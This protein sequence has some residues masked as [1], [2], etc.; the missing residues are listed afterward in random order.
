[1]TLSEKILAL[2]QCSLFEGVGDSEI[3]AIAE[4]CRA[5]KFMAGSVITRAHE[6]PQRLLI[7][8]NG[9]LQQLNGQPLSAVYDVPS[10]VLNLAPVRDVVADPQLGAECLMI[11]KSHFFTI[12]QEC[13]SVLVNVLT[14][15][16]PERSK[17]S[18]AA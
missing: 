17:A 8:T 3:T 11:S 18:F 15:A 9:S 2:R 13:P 1:M 16:D 7:V 10:L 4:I 12:I 6:V 14:E 5:R